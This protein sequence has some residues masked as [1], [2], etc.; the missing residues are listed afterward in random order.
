M[1]LRLKGVITHGHDTKLLRKDS[2][3]AA[4]GWGTRPSLKVRPFKENFGD[5]PTCGWGNKHN[6]RKDPTLAHGWGNRPKPEKEF[7]IRQHRRRSGPGKA[8]THPAAEVDMTGSC[9]DT[10]N[11][12]SDGQVGAINWEQTGGYMHSVFR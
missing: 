9:G 5:F 11:G 6:P 4:T 7:H 10:A 1:I 2:E 12:Y 3:G 8:Y